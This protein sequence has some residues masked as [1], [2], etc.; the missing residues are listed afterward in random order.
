MYICK[1]ALLIPYKGKRIYGMFD[2]WQVSPI[3]YFLT[4][5]IEK[6]EIDSIT[7][8]LSNVI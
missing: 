6:K 8:F 1:Q 5:K 7:S 2:Q 4:F 3:S